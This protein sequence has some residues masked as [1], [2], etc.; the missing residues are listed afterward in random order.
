M[1]LRTSLARLAAVAL[2]GCVPADDDTSG[3]ASATSGATSDADS[4]TDAS[5]TATSDTTS[6]STSSTSAGESEGTTGEPP[7]IVCP[8]AVAA[9]ALVVDLE[10]VGGA[11]PQRLFAAG[12]DGCALYF[13]ALIAGE[14]TLWRTDAS[15]LGTH[16]VTPEPRYFGQPIALGEQVIFFSDDRPWRTDG[17]AAGTYALMEGWALPGFLSEAAVFAGELYFAARDVVSRGVFVESEH[18]VEPWRTDGTI[19]GTAL[20]V[21]TAP[22]PEPEVG[23]P[24]GFTPRGDQLHFWAGPW[25]GTLWRT[26]GT[27][28][29]TAPVIDVGLTR[30]PIDGAPPRHGA[31]ALGERLVFLGSAAGE[32]GIWASD[33]TTPGTELLA[34]LDQPSAGGTSMFHEG[35]RFRWAALGERLYLFASPAGIPL[36]AKSPDARALGE[37]I[38][39][40]GPPVD[41]LWATDGTI[42]GTERL[43]ELATE[44][45]SDDWGVPA[46]LVEAGGRLYFY[47]L[48]ESG[49]TPLP[50]LHTSDGTAGGTAKIA[51]YDSV[52][53]LVPAPVADAVVF[54][55]ATDATG[56]E[57]QISRGAPATTE[58]LKDINPGP[59]SAS[60]DTPRVVGGRLVFV[61]DDGAHGREPWTSDGT[62]EGTTL[63][64]DINPGAASSDPAEYTALGDVIVFVAD[65]GAHGRELWKM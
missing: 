17:S 35:D 32:F 45:Y 43:V 58:L 55:A 30:A 19:A 40:Y 20:L 52:G 8:E 47:A 38:A 51:A 54:A 2:A 37:G 61:A 23:G 57:L 1:A 18:G 53:A 26:D 44:T 49:M 7:P 15:E 11:N 4:T 9:P 42:A 5:T 24:F 60:P 48:D 22:G 39:Y 64:A 13:N 34:R 28:E 29:G 25:P 12:A 14:I 62:V 16:Q 46:D 59:A 56:F 31:A 50:A 3:A 6:A 36:P 65:D 41:A 63:V 27:T 10:P 21:D 33:G